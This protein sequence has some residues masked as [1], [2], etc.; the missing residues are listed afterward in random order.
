MNTT[1][2]EAQ[3]PDAAGADNLATLINDLRKV[4]NA[5]VANQLE[6]LN[7][8][9]LRDDERE[10]ATRDPH[11]LIDS[12]AV[13][14][15]A[16]AYY[17]HRPPLALGITDALRNILVLVPIMAT[18]NAL[19]TASCAYSSAVSGLKPGEPLS[20]LLF[21]Q[22]GLASQAKDACTT[23]LSFF[24]FDTFSALAAFDFWVLLVVVLLTIAVHFYKDVLQSHAD[25]ISANL[26]DRTDQAVW[27]LGEA[28][29]K[30]RYDLTTGTSLSLAQAVASF[31]AHA[32]E[33]LDLLR[34]AEQRSAQTAADQKVEL[35]DLRLLADAW[36]DGASQ[37]LGQTEQLRAVYAQLQDAVS[38]LSAQ[39][40]ASG[41]VQ[42]KLLSSLH[43]IDSAAKQQMEATKATGIILQ[44]AMADVQNEARRNADVSAELSRNVAALPH[45]AEVLSAGE[46]SLREGLLAVPSAVQTA[47]A[48]QTVLLEKSAKELAGAY[49]QLNSDIATSSG[50][51]RASL[52]QLK[53]VRTDLQMAAGRFDATSAAN[54]SLADR[55]DH[56][57]I[58]VEQAMGEA[59]K[60]IEGNA[61]LI[62]NAVGELGKRDECTTR[63]LQEAVAIVRDLSRTVADMTTKQ[64]GAASAIEDASRQLESATVD[65]NRTLREAT[66]HSDDDRRHATHDSG[67]PGPGEDGRGRSLFGINFR[68]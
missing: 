59:H 56:S 46:N 24:R 39:L 4:D 10:L 13:E 49:A 43:A 22:S 2:S 48:A 1:R 52:E 53:Q 21:W 11:A 15:R 54:K 64:A 38:K 61:K 19:A 27:C 6:S 17:L 8:A 60:L 16:S 62:T 50:D 9:L 12:R 36:R 35:V 7:A 31:P 41:S 28:Y 45:V 23:G 55:L 65:L 40:S 3:L 44:R 25:Q 20:F 26:R 18:W 42:T 68:R 33:M 37:I 57:S 5:T 14:E 51:T 47:V 32:E 34:E 66:E 29:S 67:R 30:A 63:D 58:L